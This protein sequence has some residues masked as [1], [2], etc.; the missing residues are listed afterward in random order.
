MPQAD[1]QKGSS[2]NILCYKRKTSNHFSHPNEESFHL[3]VIE[4]ERLKP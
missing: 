2:K 4:G 1:I 3:M